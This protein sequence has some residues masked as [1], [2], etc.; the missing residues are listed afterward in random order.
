[1]AKI[2]F[3]IRDN[4]KR[5]IARATLKMSCRLKSQETWQSELLQATNAGV[6]WLEIP[7]S[8]FK[9][10][11]RRSVRF[12]VSQDGEELSHTA[13]T[14]QQKHTTTYQVLITTGGV[15]PD[16]DPSGSDTTDDSDNPGG[17][18]DG[19][20]DSDDV[21]GG[22]QPNGP[23]DNADDPST[24]LDGG[25]K[26]QYCVHGKVLQANGQPVPGVYVVAYDRGICEENVLKRIQTNDAGQYRIDYTQEQLTDSAKTSADLIV[27]VFETARDKTPLVSS[28]LFVEAAHELN[29]D[30]S[31]SSDR[32]RGQSQFEHVAAKLAP[33]ME[34]KGWDCLD[35]QDLALLSNRSGLEFVSIAQFVA[36]QLARQDVI[37]SGIKSKADYSAFFFA[38]ICSGHIANTQALLAK[39]EAMVRDVME[40][41]ITANLIP[42]FDVERFL[43]LTRS[44]RASY[45]ADDAR[46]EH[47]FYKLAGLS[48]AQKSAVAAHFLTL[49]NTAEAWRRLDQADGVTSVVADKLRHIQRASRLVGGQ[50]KLLATAQ[51]FLK[52]HRVEAYAT[53]SRE[54]WQ[55]IIRQSK[56]QLPATLA[57]DTQAAR[58]QTLANA[59]LQN[60]EATLPDQVFAQKWLSKRASAKS[61]I[62]TML[63]KHPDFVL[64]RDSI[65]DYARQN[66]KVSDNQLLEM[67]RLENLYRVAPGTGRFEVVDALWDA[68][69]QHPAQIVRLGR[70][71]FRQAYTPLLGDT[72]TV[73]AVFAS[74]QGQMAGQIADIAQNHAQLNGQ[75]LAVLPSVMSRLNTHQPL[76]SAYEELYGP[77]SL[78]YCVHCQSALSPAAYL[79]DLLAFL[80]RASN[81]AGL[82]GRE[83]LAQRRPEIE[84]IEVS[85]ANSDTVMPYID[86]VLE[87]LENAVKP[88]P[89]FAP[90][91]L[92]SAEQIAA[93]PENTDVSAY[94]KLQNKV[95]PWALPFDYELEHSRAYLLQ[96][97]VSRYQL[98]RQLRHYNNDV[99]L[100][101]AAEYLK[102]S[103]KQATLVAVPM[104]DTAA[105][106]LLLAS[107][108]GFN[109]LAEFIGADR[110]DSVMTR[111]DL[112]FNEL[113]ELFAS[114]FV[115]PAGTNHFGE[116]GRMINLSAEVLDRAHRLGRL[117]QYTGFSISELDGLLALVNDTPVTLVAELAA[118]ALLYQKSAISLAAM[119]AA[120]ALPEEE[121]SAEF[122]RLF[123]IADADAG[124]LAEVTNLPWSTPITP[125]VIWEYL[126]QLAHFNIDL[127]DAYHWLTEP[128]PGSPFDRGVLEPLCTQLVNEVALIREEEELRL[129][130]ASS[131][132]TSTVT[133]DFPSG[134]HTE[135]SETRARQI[136]VLVDKLTQSFAID[137]DLALEL[138]HRRPQSLA[139]NIDVVIS[140]TAADL[141]D[142]FTLLAKQLTLSTALGVPAARFD[143][144]AQL[145]DSSSRLL[146]AALPTAGQAK[147]YM[148]GLSNLA[149]LM[150]ISFECC[151]DTQLPDLLGDWVDDLPAYSDVPALVANATDWLES[152]VEHLLS[153]GCFAWESTEVFME[154]SGYLDLGQAMR[155]A[156]TLNVDAPT[157]W[158][159][160]DKEQFE[161][162]KEALAAL[163]SDESWLS[164]SAQLHD[165][166]REKQR[167]ALLTWL[168]DHGTGALKGL[169]D[170]LAIYNHFLI[171]PEMSACFDT[172]RIVQ[173]SAA[174]QQL[175]QRILLSMEPGFSFAELDQ[176]GWEWRKNYRVWEA[177][178]KVFLYPENWIE[179]ELRHNKTEL[180]TAFESQ[181]MQSEL[182]ADNVERAV[183]DYARQL[184]RM[185]NLEFCA[186]CEGEQNGS[187]HFF[188]RTR[189]EPRKLYH[190]KFS[191]QSWSGWAE[192]NIDANADHLLPVFHNGRLYLYW[193]ILEEFRDEEKYEAEES[194]AKQYIAALE[195]TLEYWEDTRLRVAY[196]ELEEANS[197]PLNDS[198]RDRQI[199][200]AERELRISKAAVDARR[201]HL[202][203]NRKFAEYFQIQLAWSVLENA[204]WSPVKS[205]EFR[206]NSQ[207]SYVYGVNP[208]DIVCESVFK[209]DE[210]VVSVSYKHRY[211]NL[212][213]HDNDPVDETEELEFIG[214]FYIGECGDNCSP[215]SSRTVSDANH[216]VLLSAGPTEVVN[217]VSD[218]NSWKI[219]EPG[220]ALTEKSFAWLGTTVTTDI[221]LLDSSQSDTGRVVFSSHGNGRRSGKPFVYSDSKTS[222]LVEKQS[223]T[224]VVS[225]QVI[226]RSSDTRSSRLVQATSARY[227]PLR[228]ASRNLRVSH[229]VPSV[230]S[231]AQGALS[232]VE[233]QVMY[234]PA[235]QVLQPG[236]FHIRW[237]AADSL[238]D[239]IQADD[240][241]RGYE[242][243][244]AE[245]GRWTLPDILHLP[246]LNNSGSDSEFQFSPLYHAYSCLYTRQLLRKGTSRF[247]QPDA[248]SGLDDDED[249]KQQRTPNSSYDFDS[250]YQPTDSVALEYP[251]ERIDFNLSHPYGMYNNE[252]FFYIPM[253]VATRFMQDQQFERARDWFHYIFDP[254]CT[255]GTGGSRV[256]RYRTFAN[257]HDQILSGNAEQFFGSPE[258][259]AA[260]YQQ[261]LEHPFNPHAIAQTRV[262]AYMRYVIMR[263]LDNLLAWGDSLFRQDT[264]ESIN[265]AMQLYVLAAQMLGNKPLVPE[266][267]EIEERKTVAEILDQPAISSNPSPAFDSILEL[268]GDDEAIGFLGEIL[269]FCIPQN[270]R[271]LS[272]WDTVADRLFKIRHCM[273]IDGLVREL[274]LFQPPIDPALL[275]RATAAGVSIGDVLA[276][277]SAN[278]RP[279]Y[280]FNYM[281]ARSNDFLAD[282]RQL[283]AQLLSAI[284]KNEAEQLAAIRSNSEV[285]ISDLVEEQK[286]IALDEA[287]QVLSATKKS[288]D[289]LLVTRNHYQVLLGNGLI[290]EEQEQ[291]AQDYRAQEFSLSANAYQVM[292]SIVASIPDTTVGTLSGA[293]FGGSHMSNVYAGLAGAFN[294]AASQHSF[295]ARLAGTNASWKRREMEWEL[296]LETVEKDITQLEQQ[297]VAA[298]VRVAFAEKDLET[299]KTQLEH[300]RQAD[301]FLRS[302][303]SNSELYYWLQ[304]QLSTLYFQAYQIAYD[305][306]RKAELSYRHE[307]AEPAASFINYGYWDGLHKGLSAGEQL[308]LDL[309]RMEESY[310]NHNSRD[311]ELR[312]SVSVLLLNPTALLSLKN[313][314]FCELD[315]PEYV[316]DFDY[317]GHYCRRIKSV[318][319]SIPAIVGPYTSVNCTLTLINSRLR[320]QIGDEDLEQ[321]PTVAGQRIATSS[322]QNDTGTFQFDFRDERYLPF[323]GEGAISSWKLQLA[324]PEIAQFDYGS[325]S[326]VILHLNYTAKSA[327]DMVNPDGEAGETWR[328]TVTHKLTES[329]DQFIQSIGELPVLLDPE[330]VWPGEWLAFKANAASSSDLRSLSLPMSDQYLPFATRRRLSHFSRVE[331]YAL[332][333]SALENT[334]LELES[335]GLTDDKQPDV[336]EADNRF[337]Q[338]AETGLWKAS[339]SGMEFGFETWS[340][341]LPANSIAA[342][343]KMVVVA[344]YVINDA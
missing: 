70:S 114:R 269:T 160:K 280:R 106:R 8:I 107:Y 36:A 206:I 203:L 187:Y 15:A 327:E 45:V 285:I 268:I 320:R 231:P 73:D 10:I 181:L 188:A 5:A 113:Q 90:Q 120:W 232:V 42:S 279:L 247:Y 207:S 209:R 236:G 115:N 174:A 321:L 91:T 266:H 338:D 173:A 334:V 270:D 228:S 204:S 170:E 274:A 156:N 263:Y 128:E 55:Q 3:R 298:E 79:V 258:K 328:D 212:I 217:A 74:A 180:F 92:G 86:L 168:M 105:K 314:G 323:E 126:Q 182:T 177:N 84:R 69:I 283:G 123:G 264:R 340:L 118:A 294:A 202:A 198:D 49:G 277:L 144:L 262:V 130:D 134:F 43:A 267:V 333:G 171:D 53:L 342:I 318:S 24:D 304:Q 284:E 71:A 39:P 85:C 155:M 322:A 195:D 259:F 293:T 241:D 40:Q 19:S 94:A 194:L 208:A 265:E 310:I 303:F 142:R 159:L 33:F 30:L 278:G 110:I 81:S 38:L 306:A 101:A 27:R 288:M 234:Q 37:K 76:R 201:Y 163:Y 223:A 286:N 98:L 243:T 308:A 132:E 220:L 66:L 179:P 275:V 97:G 9:N 26:P 222:Y 139:L 239:L 192:V 109:D 108:W 242:F 261:W 80:E 68:G 221:S 162:A 116:D 131:L 143:K 75:N 141:L 297:I 185:S 151:D 137:A 196:I 121:R 77:Y 102:L 211:V 332:G 219:K 1:M 145:A 57:G 260:Q 311:L 56:I 12:Q 125:M 152:D 252:M 14:F 93:E 23:A 67:Q 337:T 176:Q 183:L 237:P 296:Q 133:L 300:S 307:L 248:A 165:G 255:Q 50:M 64:G 104:H 89:G 229:R 271:M 103:A 230:Y 240:D 210:L 197:L 216:L 16:I 175:V 167:D 166:L 158:S 235:Q 95:Y 330:Q 124:K 22:Q 119:E 153:K 164:V 289:K 7:D 47:S 154:Q 2:Q 161:T 25:N 193:L 112:S 292:S 326:D 244:Q 87:V 18:M 63:S 99:Q 315:I 60:V 62:K 20:L 325:I 13:S 245:P 149:A 82:N 54:D 305:M 48:K 148:S 291:L 282:V 44:E 136:Q 344:H 341:R 4:N 138:I 34:G 213:I 200:N 46:V 287:R 331:V 11:V 253:L 111:T 299:S 6:I 184:H 72:R 169:S 21:S 146:F 78:Q 178:R 249:L 186:F 140:S 313:M 214:E 343:E 35:A 51:T 17:G 316:F 251:I 150:Q 301:N 135:A 31:V 147:K 256:W 122:A 312:K 157:L 190:T 96:S 191:Q 273:N 41:A 52:T 215:E 65:R 59:M 83:L 127:V 317:P 225:R 32:Y 329:S 290:E 100:D 238:L 28:P 218:Y 129:H 336:A 224:P 272:Y 324:P 250:L 319:I 257:T 309:R 276:G 88:Q 339:F 335:P 189:G 58:M 205:S 254:T 295:N 281:L 227:R 61:P 199:A 302:K 233:D 226:S 117:R 29:V 172:S 246:D